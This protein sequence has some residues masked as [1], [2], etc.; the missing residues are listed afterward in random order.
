MH[1]DQIP[2]RYGGT[3]RDLGVLEAIDTFQPYYTD[4]CETI[5]APSG[6]STTDATSNSDDLM[7][8]Q[9]GDEDWGKVRDSSTQMCSPSE[10]S[11]WSGASYDPDYTGGKR[12]FKWSIDGFTQTPGKISRPNSA[13]TGTKTKSSTS[14]FSCLW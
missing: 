12:T 14:I 7:Y 5:I 13:M 2:A 11:C 10:L 6:L 3:A 1:R 4:K 9:G 8:L